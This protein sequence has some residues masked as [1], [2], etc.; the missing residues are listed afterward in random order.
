MLQGI[1]Y[2]GIR[3]KNQ[4]FTSD[5]FGKEAVRAKRI[6]TMMAPTQEMGGGRPNAAGRY[7]ETN[8]RPPIVKA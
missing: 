1:G 4:S 8:A 3:M 2:K 7:P 5:G 6:M